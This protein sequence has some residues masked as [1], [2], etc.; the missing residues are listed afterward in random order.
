MKSVKLVLVILGALALSLIEP[1]ALAQTQLNAQPNCSNQ[2]DGSEFGATPVGAAVGVVNAVAVGDLNGNP[3]GSTELEYVTVG[4]LQNQVSGVTNTIPY[5]QIWRFGCPTMQKLDTIQPGRIFGVLR[6]VAVGNFYGG[7]AQLEIVAV[8]NTTGGSGM[9]IAIKWSGPGVYTLRVNYW[10]PAGDTT[11]AIYG[12]ASADMNFDTVN[13]VWF[14]G[15]ATY[16]TTPTLRTFVGQFVLN[17][18]LSLGTGNYATFTDANHDSVADRNSGWALSFFPG[19]RAN[20]ARMFVTGEFTS[21]GNIETGYAWRMNV[22]VNGV[23]IYDGI[24]DI[25]NYSPGVHTRGGS[26]AAFLFGA[27]RVVVIGTSADPISLACPGFAAVRIDDYVLTNHPGFDGSNLYRQFQGVTPWDS[28]GD[29]FADQLLAVGTYTNTGGKSYCSGTNSPVYITLSFSPW[30]A[31]VLQTVNTWGIPVD[32]A[33][34]GLQGAYGVVAKN[35]AW[36]SVE[37]IITASTV[38]STSL[39]RLVGQAAIFRETKFLDGFDDDCNI[40]PWTV[41]VASGNTVQVKSTL[42]YSSPCSLFISYLGGNGPARATT[43]SISFD[44]TKE[45][46]VTTRFYVPSVQ[47]HPGDR[48]I[49]VMDDSRAAVGD[50]FGTLYAGGELS[51]VAVTTITYDTWH[52]I[53]IQAHPGSSTFNVVVDGVTYGPYAFYASGTATTISVGS[54]AAPGKKEYADAYWDDIAVL[55]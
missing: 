48:Y 54:R 6:S 21:S 26:I 23:P 49:T 10:N 33:L 4:Y 35:V 11:T 16:T 25:W 17:S 20:P 37:E 38:W 5:I 30:N 51:G 40:S 7:D 42:S 45:Y 44:R 2:V 50:I 8:G 46:S 14:T 3:P 55:V 29:G 31:P 28:D 52:T 12:A 27:Y 32:T 53:E 47:T 34:I 22:D 43:P 13:E 1:G 36:T 18:D 39:N 19:A 9:A 41:S 24:Q 15:R